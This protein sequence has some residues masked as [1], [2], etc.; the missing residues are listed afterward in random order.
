[1]SPERAN[2]R[3]GSSPGVAQDRQQAT[4]SITS[5]ATALAED[6]SADVLLAEVDELDP[7]GYA[8]VAVYVRPHVR[9]RPPLFGGAA[10]CALVPDD[11]LRWSAVVVAAWD[12]WRARHGLTPP[13]V[14]QAVATELKAASLT[15]SGAL[16]WRRVAS[17]HITAA[18]L[19]RRRALSATRPGDYPGGPVPVWGPVSEAGAV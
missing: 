16:D 18:D 6:A 12:D 11:P 8:A 10:W 4:A 5:D 9:T 13:A 17:D 15:V 1:M 19:Q 14:E 2:A 7:A 3:G